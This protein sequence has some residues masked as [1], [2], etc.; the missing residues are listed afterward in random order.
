MDNL[1]KYKVPKYYKIVE[2]LPK[3]NVGK[4]VRN[5]VSELYG[6]SDNN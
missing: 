5:K 4:I 6:S 1:A 3:N 2:D